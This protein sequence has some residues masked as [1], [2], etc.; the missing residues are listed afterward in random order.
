MR[1]Q[2]SVK[3]GVLS[4]LALAAC[5]GPAGPAGPE[6]E[7]GAAGERGPTGTTGPRGATRPAGEGGTYVRGD[8]GTSTL[9]DSGIAIQASCLSPCHGFNGVVAQYQ[10]SAHYLEY[11]TNAVSATPET[12]W[13]TPGVACGNCHAI[14]ALAQRAAGTVRTV[15]DGGVANLTKGE[16]EYL[17]PVNG[18]VNDALYAGSSTVAE[19]YCT[20]CHAV[21]D[22]ND[23]HRTGKPWTPGSFPLVVADEADAGAF[24]E[25]SPTTSAVT[26]TSAGDL[27]PGNTCVWCHKSRKDVTQ[28]IVPMGNK[29]SA[30]WGPHEG[31]Q[32]DVFSAKG[33]YEYP[34]QTYG[35]S[36]HELKLS[37]VDCHMAPVTD[38]QNVGNH[39]FTPS[40][41]VCQNCHSGATS[42]DIN[43]GETLDQTEMFELEADLNAAGDLTRSTSAPY[44][45]LSAANLTDGQFASDSPRSGAGSVDGGTAGISASEAGALYNYL[46]IA[47]GGGS[48]VHNPKYMQ[49]L[50]FDSVVALTTKPPHS[51]PIR[52]E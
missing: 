26:G 16:L 49:Q 6:G 17:D 32:A 37:C 29:L 31:P 1:R 18:T 10:T 41:S 4:L 2:S 13:T 23:P 20:T 19:V 3:L 7:A 33:G 11:L 24:L 5:G 25:K 21:T 28:Y 22:T 51:L 44:L 12:E 34:G 47:K 15:D 43:G 40:I 9:T 46:L 35:T 52:P 39:S 42:F 45:P 30:Y 50:I 36:T 48:G 38:T 27:G 8:A 14:D